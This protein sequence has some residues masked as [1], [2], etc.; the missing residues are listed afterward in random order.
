MRLAMA[1]RMAVSGRSSYS[2]AGRGGIVKARRDGAAAGAGAGVGMA[3]G[4]AAA[5][6]A[7]AASTSRRMMRPPGP[8]PWTRRRSTPDW[9]ATF[10]AS[11]EA[12]TRS[13]RRHD[14]RS[15]RPERAGTAP[16]GTTVAVAGADE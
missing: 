6:A 8:E 3:A 1:A 5:G 2:A 13:P 15:G 7:A 10:R 11:G 9:A 12:F 16:I 14:G 4:A